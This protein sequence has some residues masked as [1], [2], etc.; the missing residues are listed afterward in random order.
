LRFHTK[1]DEVE[2]DDKDEPVEICSTTSITSTDHQAS[3][4]KQGEDQRS[5]DAVPLQGPVRPVTHTGQTSADRGTPTCLMAKKE[6][7]SKKKRQ[8]KGARGQKIEVSSSPARELEL[9]KSE[10]ASLVCKYESL[11]N[12]Y[13]HDIKSFSYRA[14]VEKEANDALEAQLAKLTC[15]H[16]ALQADH[17]G[18]ECSYEKLVDSYATL[19]IAH[20]VMLSLVK[21]IQPPSHT[22]TCSQ[23]QINLSCANDYLSQASQSSFE[24]ELV[25]SCDDLVAKEN[26][27]LKQEVEKLQKDLYVLKEKSKVQ[28]SQDNREDM[29]KKL[30][31]GSTVTSSTP[32][33]YAMTHKNKIQEKSKVGQVKSQYRPTKHK[34]QESFYKKPRSSN[35]W[36]V[37]YKCREKG[38]FTDSCPSVKMSCGTDRDRSDRCMPPVRPVPPG[39]P[40]LK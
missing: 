37:C 33:Q 4:L 36:R 40:P 39:L 29:V 27:E 30:E 10:L 28:P 2:S 24:H 12:K 13:D 3:T 21:S 6:K 32:Q 18:L 19:E 7:K 38:H 25:E 8:A 20:E 22:C 16:M 14:K 35:K 26:D 9:L 17:K 23:V 15:E 1:W 5:D 11:A 34:A 31:M